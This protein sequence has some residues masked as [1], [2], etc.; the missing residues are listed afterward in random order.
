MNYDTNFFQC[1]FNQCL[2]KLNLIYDN[3]EEEIEGQ[4]DIS[5]IL[6]IKLKDKFLCTACQVQ[7]KAKMNLTNIT[8]RRS[9][10]K[11]LIAMR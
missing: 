7:F 3:I 9:T 8:K 10:R 1:T 2:T 11:L 6:S 4:E 5:D